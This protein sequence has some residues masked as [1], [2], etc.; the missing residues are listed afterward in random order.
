MVNLSKEG[1]IKSTIKIIFQKY[2]VQVGCLPHTK[3][4]LLFVPQV[5]PNMRNQNH[6]PLLFAALLK[7]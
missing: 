5:L 6:V 1:G 7:S 3:S 4:H 2:L